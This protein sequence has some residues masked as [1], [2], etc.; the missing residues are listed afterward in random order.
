M[1]SSDP[2]STRLSLTTRLV[3]AM[4]AVTLVSIA[5]MIVLPL[6]VFRSRLETLPP[7][8]RRDV[9]R[10][11][12]NPDDFAALQDIA[13]TPRGIGQ[14]L[15]EVIRRI[16]S[17]R[18]AL[19]RPL[20][21]MPEGPS[22]PGA[23]SPNGTPPS[24]IQRPATTN[25]PDD[26]QERLLRQQVLQSFQRRLT[27]LEDIAND[28]R[29]ERS[30]NLLLSAL[31]AC[32]VA[33]TIAVLVARRIAKPVSSVARAAQ[34][35]SGGDLSARAS[36][37]GPSDLETELLAQNFNHMAATLEQQEGERTT[38][39]A[40]IAHELRTP[41]AVMSARLTALEDGVLPLDGQ[42]VNRLQRHTQ[43]LTRLVD[44]LRTLSLFDAGR[45]TLEQHQLDLRD[46][47]DNVANDASKRAADVNIVLDVP[48]EPLWIE[49]DGLRLEQVFSN[50]VGNAL[51]HA[52]ST[53]THL[54][55]NIRAGQNRS[56]EIWVQVEDS[57]LG[58]SEEAL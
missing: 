29:A 21:P 28:V 43:R 39:I 1:R 57:G 15:P 27:T 3:V 33:A 13:N 32:L 53:D 17:A 5:L 58:L 9:E 10:I 34:Q 37:V 11:L 14:N 26:S 20:R 19:G 40:N 30:R 47:L 24:N 54:A 7:N 55:V 23:A 35:L 6:Y 51:R 36:L 4:V 45:L 41:L 42:E 44:D 2:P 48:D 52:S 8:I 25:T 50:L 18:S 49:G 16:G 31:A 12:E 38:M 46:V 22:T 56:Q